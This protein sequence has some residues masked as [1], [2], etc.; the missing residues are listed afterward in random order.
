M[1]RQLR[2]F[3]NVIMS[4]NF[5]KAKYEKSSNSN[6]RF[7]SSRYIYPQNFGIITQIPEFTSHRARGVLKSILR[8]YIPP[9]IVVMDFHSAFGANLSQRGYLGKMTLFLLNLGIKPLYSA[10]NCPGDEE[11]NRRPLG[12]FSEDFFRK[13]YFVHHKEGGGVRLENFHLE[14]LKPGTS[15]EDIKTK[16]PFFI[17]AFT[18]E[19]L[20]NRHMSRFMENEILFLLVVKKNGAGLRQTGCIHILG[21]NIELS[22][23]LIGALVFCIMDLKKRELRIFEVSEG[24]RFNKVK[25]VSVLARNI[26]YD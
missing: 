8:T 20:E 14:Y 7:L 12:I 13:L 3:G 23:Q 1:E 25:R 16:N 21:V 10:I 24:G 4:L 15:A 26:I 17:N 19:D 22:T 18:D 6:I 5:W 9:D 2:R 11:D